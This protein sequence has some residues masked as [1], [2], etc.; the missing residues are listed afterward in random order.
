MSFRA[1]GDSFPA[2]CDGILRR[3]EM[4]CRVGFQA[5]VPGSSNRSY[6]DSGRHPLDTV[7]SQQVV[8]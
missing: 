8:E 5:M 4:L 3:E 6:K 2:P 1:I 7:F